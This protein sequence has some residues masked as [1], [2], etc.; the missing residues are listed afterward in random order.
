MS[1]TEFDYV[2][3]TEKIISFLQ[4]VGIV[5]ILGC[6]YRTIA[7]KFSEFTSIKSTIDNRWYTVRKSADKQ[8]AA[9]TLA[10]L[11]GKLH[12]LI[13]YVSSPKNAGS[14]YDPDIQRLVKRFDPSAISEASEFISNGE[15]TSY[16]VNKGEKVSFCLKCRK[17]GDSNTFEPDNTLVFV[18]IHELSHISNDE[19]GHGEKFQ[20]LNKY[21]L[22]KATECGVWTYQD[23]SSQPVKYCGTVINGLPK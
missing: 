9:N 17:C 16:T 10:A 5:I 7:Y 3:D 4:I 2:L 11:T 23:Y 13:E 1:T 12:T 6:L 15:L 19:V 21:F 8:T 22:D 14:K 20:Q 18:G